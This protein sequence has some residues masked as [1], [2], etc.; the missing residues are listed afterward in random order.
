MRIQIRENDF[1][2]TIIFPTCLVYNRGI[3]WILGT[4]FKKVFPDLPL[5]KEEIRRLQRAV[6]KVKKQYW[7]L[8]LI[9]IESKDDRVKIIL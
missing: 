3:G 7:R 8:E 6:R 4:V 1:K 9:S 5:G 2:F